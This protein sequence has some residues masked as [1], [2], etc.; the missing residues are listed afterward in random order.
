MRDEILEQIK[1]HIEDS[2]LVEFG[3]DDLTV[4][5]DLFE[6]G[7]FDSMAMVNFTAFLEQ[8]FDVEIGAE[9]IM[10]GDL[11]SAAKSADYVTALKQT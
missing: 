5:S 10:N 2:F 3:Q 7:V 9:A 6:E 4:D 11:V 8:E 1:S